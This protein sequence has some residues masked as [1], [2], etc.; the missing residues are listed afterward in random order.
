MW[1]PE[2]TIY[3]KCMSIIGETLHKYA[4]L[5]PNDLDNIAPPFESFNDIDILELDRIPPY[6][7]SIQ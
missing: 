3:N 7:H 1:D 4:I 2:S 6:A 5:D